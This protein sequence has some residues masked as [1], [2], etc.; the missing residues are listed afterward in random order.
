M[1]KK[2]N[3]FI[4][5][6]L[7]FALVLIGV[8]YNGIKVVSAATGLNMGGTTIRGYAYSNSNFAVYN[9]TDNYKRQIG[10]CY[11]SS[12]YITISGVG[13]DGWSKI[14][15]PAGSTYKTGYCQSSYLFQNI[16]F[17]GST[18]RVTQ[19]ITTYTK[20]SCSSSFG[21]T[22]TGDYVFIVGYSNGNTQILYPCSGYYKV[23]WIKGQYT[24]SN[25]NLC[26]SATS[27]NPQ[28]YF[29]AAISNSGNKL[30]VRGWAFDRDN[31]NSKLAI[32]IYVGG[33]AGSG[34]PCYVVTAN[35]SRA[36]VNNVYP[37]VGNYHGF[38]STIT[39]SK[40]GNQTI[41]VYAINVG[42]GSNVLLGTKTVNIKGSTSYNPQGYFDAAISAVDNK[43]TVRGWAF[44]RDN[45]NSKLAI[46][47]YVGGPAGSG[48][49]CYG[50]TANTSRVDVN[51]AYPGVGNYHGFYS[52]I[53]VNKTGYQTIYAYAINVGGG[54]NV[55]LGT[56]QV[57]IKGGN[58]LQWQYPMTNAYV[59]GNNWRTYYS[60]RP[61]RPY[62]VGL[63]LA[64]R[65]GSTTVNAAASGTV[66]K[67]GYNSANGNYVVIRHTLSGKT[68]YSFY[69]HLRSYCVSVNQSVSKGQNIGVMGNTGSGSVGAHLHFAIAD[70]LMSGSYYGY[71]PYFTGNKTTYGGCTFYNPA[72]VIS[73]NKLP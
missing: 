62:H 4:A 11:G 39:V 43:L 53:T 59:C 23:A 58:E 45:L 26:R 20:A 36:D 68:V 31:L 46:H 28:G 30:T 47:I 19:N 21:T 25:G 44:D 14:T 40:T 8:N 5:F 7:T 50:V 24:I 16:N 71:V 57:Y 66:A 6:V 61:S 42:G 33:P 52:T 2:L 34:A 70:T 73:N 12:D 38:D 10:T 22:T 9:R 67:V 17:S 55:L 3:R 32:H 60:A 69:A 64:S 48:A 29:D 56:K 13:S 49:P 65:T 35:T 51:N 1:V 15:Y 54:S 18:G 27:Y 37:G 72:Y 41:Y 63:D